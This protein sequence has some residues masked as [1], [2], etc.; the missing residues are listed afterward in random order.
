MGRWSRRAAGLVMF[1]QN[2]D[3]RGTRTHFSGHRAV[4]TVEWQLLVLSVGDQKGK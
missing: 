4:R 2:P 1:A 3:N